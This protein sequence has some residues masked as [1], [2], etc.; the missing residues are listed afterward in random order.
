MRGP[1]FRAPFV[2]SNLIKIAKKMCGSQKCSVPWCFGDGFGASGL[3][4]TG[5]LSA[6]QGSGAPR[7]AGAWPGG[8][9]F[10]RPGV[11]LE[12]V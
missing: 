8:A 3:S 2:I 7:D 4:L 10:S 1:R 5:A 12:S 9:R 6:G 11:F